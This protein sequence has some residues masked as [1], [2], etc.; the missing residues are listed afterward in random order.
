MTEVNI[1]HTGK[2]TLAVPTAGSMQLYIR[3]TVKSAEH[4]P[5]RHDSLQLQYP[6]LI[7]VHQKAHI[8]AKVTINPE[9]RTRHR[10]TRLVHSAI[11]SMLPISPV[12]YATTAVPVAVP[13]NAPAP[14]SSASQRRPS[15]VY[16]ARSGASSACASPGSTAVV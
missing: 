3:M 15:A 4:M 12:D 10:L 13:T 14:D 16:T 8:Q 7:S 1:N 5:A 9:Q 11:K 6:N 2:M